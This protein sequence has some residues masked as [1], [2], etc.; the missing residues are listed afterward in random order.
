MGSPVSFAHRDRTSCE[1]DV[2][3]RITV[4]NRGPV[5]MP[6]NFLLYGALLQLY[7][8]YG[9]SF[10]VECPTGSGRQATLL[11][12]AKELG[13]RLGRVFLRGRDGRRLAGLRRNRE[14]PERSSLAGSG[15]VLR[16]LTRRRRRGHR[17]QPPDGLDWVRR[18]DPSGERPRDE[19][20]PPRSGCDAARDAEGGVPDRVPG[21]TVGSP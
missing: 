5:W 8:Y 6:V 14:V 19:G 3:I 10:T 2:L 16:I 18:P 13:E 1:I 9:D 20:G 15:P 21:W 4:V 12:V 17:R 11:E 7:T